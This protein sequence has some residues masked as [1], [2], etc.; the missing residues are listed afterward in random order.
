MYI[1]NDKHRATKHRIKKL[2]K[3]SKSLKEFSE[4]LEQ[5]F[6][7]EKIET[8]STKKPGEP[9]TV[10]IRITLEDLPRAIR[11]KLNARKN[12]IDKLLEEK[13]MND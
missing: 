9:T 13:L 5:T 2:L 7:V 8:I 3:E 6:K 4:K 1:M 10:V 11:L 12:E